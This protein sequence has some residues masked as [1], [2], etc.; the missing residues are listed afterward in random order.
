ML[1]TF[2]LPGFEL[3][4]AVWHGEGG[5][6][7]VFYIDLDLLMPALYFHRRKLFGVTKAV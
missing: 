7:P 5:L 4:E 3:L 1:R 6:L 2:P